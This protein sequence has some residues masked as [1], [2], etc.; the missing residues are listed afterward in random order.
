MGLMEAYF[1]V[2]DWPVKVFG[3]SGIALLLQSG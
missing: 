2:A 1:V 3:S